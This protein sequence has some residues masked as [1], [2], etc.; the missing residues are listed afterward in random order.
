MRSLGAL[1][2][3]AC[4]AACGAA[5]KPIPTAI[6]ASKMTA[7]P[8]F[9]VTLFAGEPAVVQ[10]IAFTFDDRGR[11]WVVECLSYPKWSRDGK[12]H[13]R[14]VILEDTDGDGVLRQAHRLHGQRHQPLRHRTWG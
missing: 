9:N 2:L 4:A 3:L 7:P 13:D 12:G 11:M 5:D 1:T 8:G 10:P 14:V 6:A